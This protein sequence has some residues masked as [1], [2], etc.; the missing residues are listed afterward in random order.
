MRKTAYPLLIAMCLAASRLQGAVAP[1]IG[2]AYPAGGIPGTTFTVTIGGQYLKDFAGIHVSGLSVTARLSDYLRIYEQREIGRIRR[3]K[4]TL[5]A[6]MSEEKDATTRHQVQRILDQVNQEM[7]EVDEMLREQRQ[8]PTMTA[9]R[10]FNPQIAERVR[11]DLTLPQDAAPGNYELRVVTTNGLS[12]PILF[13]VGHLAE[14][15]ESEP[16][17]ALAKTEWLS[18]LPALINGQVMPGDVDCFRFRGTKG[19]TLVMKADARALIPYLADAV[20]G[21]LQ[22]V[23]TLYDAKGVEIARNDDYQGHPDP[24]LIHEIP[25]DGDYTLSIRDA[26]YRG[27]EDFVYRLSIGE[28]PFI[29]RIEPFGGVINSIENV[30][31]FGV[32]LPVDRIRL[33]TG[34]LAAMLPVQVRSGRYLSNSRPF[35]VSALPEAKEGEP[36]DLATQARTIQN[37]LVINGKMN[38]PGDVDWFSLTGTPGQALTV[39]VNARRLGSP[40]DAR[41]MLLD[42][43]QQVLAVS[44]DAEDKGNGLATHHAD[45][46]IDIN[47]PQ[48]GTYYIRLDDAQGRGGADVSYRLTLVRQTPDFQLRLVPASL[49]IPKEGSVAATVHAVRSGAF[50]DEIT[51]ALRGSTSGLELRQNVIAAGANKATIVIAATPQAREGLSHLELDGTALCA[52]QPV[53]RPVV[54][55]EDMMQAFLYRHLVPAQ[56][57]LVQ[58]APQDPVAVTLSPPVDD[59]YGVRA[60]SSIRIHSQVTWRDDARRGIKLAL[61]DPPEWLTLETE[62]IPPRGGDIILNIS[63]NAEVGDTATVLLNGTIRVPKDPSAPDYNPIAKWMNNTDIEVTIGAIPVAI[64]E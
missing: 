18:D 21:W 9:R 17:D 56:Q 5:D 54:P 34:N 3:T 39:E 53:R 16:N 50:N 30:R 33:S 15:P 31:L 46:R 23:L 10:Q 19:Q 57:L 55:A 44:D 26:I 6:R 8:N 12:N 42:V 49:R 27:R 24:V 63:S 28:L 2:F 37:A 20:P 4:E 60:G 38:A 58:I 7:Q 45:A 62:R 41:L 22:A 51:L 52:G 36:N 35:S 48:E 11:L 29:E 47:L 64:I 59:H 61:A 14:K 43:R 40:M 13:Q 32:N 25:E 1:H